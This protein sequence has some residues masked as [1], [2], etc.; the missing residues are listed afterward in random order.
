VER[1]VTFIKEHNSKAEYDESFTQSIDD[2]ARKCLAGK[3]K[4]EAA[5]DFAALGGDGEDTKFWEALEVAVTKDKIGTSAL[6]RALKVGY[7]RAASIID[8]M[9]ELGFVGPDPGTKQGRKVYITK[10]Q[11]AEYK[12]NGLP[13]SRE[14]SG[15]DGEEGEDGGEL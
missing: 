7:G 11:L 13:G 9:E 1:V 10:Q 14:D 15:E 6:Q 5:D 8:R 12:V 2:E 4:G 3:K